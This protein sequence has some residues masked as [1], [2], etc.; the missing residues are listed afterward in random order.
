M[1]DRTAEPQ[2]ARQPAEERARLDVLRSLGL[3]DTAPEERF[4]RLTRLATRIFDVPIAMIN[5]VDT[6]R[7]WAKSRVGPLAQENPRSG[8]FCAR[9]VLGGGVVQRLDGEALGR[10]NL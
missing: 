4:D 10:Q 5:L 2:P 8:S 1:T 3:L 6:N 7:L 9:T